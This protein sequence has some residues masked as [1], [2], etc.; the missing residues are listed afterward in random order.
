[1][2]N[3][4]KD[5]ETY[6]IIIGVAFYVLVIILFSLTS[7]ATKIVTKSQKDSIIVHTKVDTLIK[8]SIKYITITKE[9]EKT[10]T[11]KEDCKT[12]MEIRQ[13][14]RTKRDS[15]RYVYKT[16]RDTV[17]IKSNMIVD[18]TS[19][20]ERTQR[21]KNRQ[22]GRTERGFWNWILIVFIAFILGYST[23]KI[24]KQI[25]G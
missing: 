1:M 12:K 5:T 17:K 21:Q 3:K 20:K 6:L 8:D 11:I 23:S 19:I 22:E 10:V 4:D 13:E 14:N 16:I 24:R 15:L 18:T 9:V 2:E 25:Y 7:C